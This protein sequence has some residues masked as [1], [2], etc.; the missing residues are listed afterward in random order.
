MIDF[1]KLKQILQENNSFLLTTHVN[2]DGDAIGSEIAVYFILKELGKKIYIINHS[3]TP[4]NLEFLDADKVIEKYDENKHQHIFDE[5][6]VLVA[7]DFNRS[8]RIVSMQGAFDKS[9]KIKICID[10]HQDSAPFVDFFF[11]DINYSATGHIIYDLIKKT[12]I[13][14]LKYQ[15]ALPIYAAIMTD[16]GSFRFERTTPELH[17]VIADLLSQNVVPGDVYDKIYDQSKFSKIKLI[18]A[19]LESIQ[20]YGTDNKIAYMV[21]KQET[22]IRLG[23]FESDTD[24]LVNYTLSVEGVVIGLMFMELKDGFKVSFRSKGTIPMNKLAGEFGGGGHV[25]A[26]GARLFNVKLDEYIPKILKKTEE[27]LKS[28]SGNSN[29]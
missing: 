28:N 10:H 25:N 29:V 13:V 8:D 4:Y 18:G 27:Y 11:A 1:N 22:F 2:P 7:L 15:T 20:L 19:A 21:L 16:T 24:S 5:V 17:Y 12:G 14:K 26:S 6:D 3:P 23:A 9:K